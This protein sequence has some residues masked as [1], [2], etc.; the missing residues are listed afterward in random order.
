MRNKKIHSFLPQGK[1]LYTIK[2][3]L[4]IIM[5]AKSKEEQGLIQEKIEDLLKDNPSRSYSK[6]EIINLLSSDLFTKDKIDRI[7]GEMEI[8]SSMKD[9]Q[10]AVYSSC[11]GG[12]VYFQWGQTP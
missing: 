12:T 7:L 1:N 2:E 10:L 11:K 5:M 9:V 6:E 3:W 4:I 8:G